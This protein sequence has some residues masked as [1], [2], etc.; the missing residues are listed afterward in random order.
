MQINGFSLWSDFIE[1][2]F[3]DTQFKELLSKQIINGATSNPAIFKNSLLTSDAYKM[4]L[5]KTKGSAKEKYE[6]LALHDIKKAA[7]VL[8]PYFDAG[9][10]GYVSIEVDPHLCDDAE[11]TFEEGL[12][13]FKTIAMPNVMIKVP[14]TDAGYSAMKKLVKANIPVNATLIFSKAQALKCCEAFNMTDKSVDTVISIFVSRFDRSL[15]SICE[16]NSIQTA[17]TGIY[18]ATSIYYAIEEH[19]IAKNRA[20]FASTGVKGDALDPA[21][22]IE[23]LLFH[24]V[25]NTAPIATIDA[26]IAK[27]TYERV[28]PY[29][30]EMIASHFEKLSQ[31]GIDFDK[32]CD[33]QLTDGLE[34]FKEAF[35]AILDALR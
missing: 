29:S 21:Y 34:A 9:N 20:L 28:Q 17:L 6:A 27:A 31:A 3:I 26:F 19:A 24:N 7:E 23:K 8:K 33:K 15:D 30:K 12:R 22:Y 32:E 18:N 35:N 14:A 10:D 5:E 13:I 1:R 4:Q 11:A 2:D 25:V 16:E